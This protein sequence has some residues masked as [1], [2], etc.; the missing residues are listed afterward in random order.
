[1]TR[2]AAPGPRVGGGR[3]RVDAAR[4]I[5]KLREYQLVERAAWVLEGIRAAVAARAT[6]IVLAGDANDIWLSWRGEPWPAEDLTRLFDELVSPEAASERHHLRLLAAAVNSGL[7]LAPAYI[8]VIAIHEH[9]AIRARYTPDVL[10]DPGVDVVDSPLRNMKTETIPVPD[11]AKPGMRV[12]LRRRASLQVL[13]YL[14]GE[15]PELE[16]ARKACADIPVLLTIGANRYHRTEQSRDVVRVPLGDGLEGFLAISDPDTATGTIMEV[17]ERG[18]ILARYPLELPSDVLHPLLSIRLLIDAPRMPTNASRSQV[19]RGSHPIAAAEQRV[20][21]LVPKLIAQLIARLG[22]A[23][24]G[25]TMAGL[26]W[27]TPV[28]ATSS[29]RPLAELPLLRD[30]TGA[31]RALLSRWSGLV[32]RGRTPL[33]S[34]LQ[35]WVDDIVWVPPGD[36]SERLISGAYHQ[37]GELRRRLR[38]ARQQRRD[39]DRFFAHE[40]R[41]PTVI[42]KT[43]PL[44][45]IRLGAEVAGSCVPQDV[46]AGLEGEVCIHLGDGASE[47]VV[48]H[49]GREI[50]RIE[51]TSPIRFDVVIDAPNVTPAARFREL[52]RDGEYARVER[53]MRAGVLRAIEAIAS[54]AIRDPAQ[55]APLI[56]SG[57]VLAKSLGAPLAPPLSTAPAWRTID[58]GC[59]AHAALGEVWAVGI[60]E[61]GI[62]VAPVAGR[63][64][65]R[66]DQRERTR[67]S[68]VA[69]DLVRI[70]YGAAAARPADP[71]DLASR[72]AR[73]NG[74]GL[75]ITEDARS[76]AIGPIGPTETSTIT[77]YHRGLRLDSKP[78][79]HVL[80]PC[81]IA[82]DSDTI[83]P[84]STW[85]R[86][87][88]EG[89]A[90]G[91]Y[92][93][94]EVALVRAA[95][96]ALVGD[97]SLDLIGPSEVDLRGGL[98][99]SMCTALAG[100]GATE[101]L[102][103]ELLA[104]VRAQRMWPVLGDP[105]PKSIDQLC[106][107]HP[108]TIPY[109]RPGAVAVA[110][111]SPLVADDVLATAVATL[112]GLPVRE[113][114]LELETHRHAEVRAKH[115]AKHL[116]RPVQPL[117]Q[118]FTGET[119]TISGPIVRGVVGVAPMAMEIEVFVEGRPFHLIRREELLPLRAAVEIG[120][121]LTMPAF[122]GIPDDVTAEIIAR[123]TEAAHDLLLAIAAA[124]PF[125]L[126][127]FGATR[128]LFAEWCRLATVPL[129]AVTVL[130][131]AP[132]FL[133]VQGGRT[134]IA[135]ACCPL[136]ATTTWTGAW[137]AQDND[138]PHRCDAPVVQITDSTDD[139]PT[140]LRAVHVGEIQDLTDDI[141]RLQATRRMTRGLM[142]KPTIQGVA[143]ELKRSF[144]ELGD[145][146]A[147]LG[148]GEI[149]L[150]GDEGSSA[151]LH[152]GGEL[153]KVVPISVSPSIQI[154]LEAPE[155]IGQ[156]EI[157]IPMRG[158]AFQLK[159]LK[160]DGLLDETKIPQ[161][162]G[163]AIVLTRKILAEVPIDSVGPA[164]RRNLV[165][166]M[167][168]GTLDV[169]ELAG[170]PVF[171]TTVP[172]WIDPV[173]VDKQINL[174]GN[175]WSV[176]HHDA[177]PKPLDDR[178]LVLRIDPA[179]IALA[180]TRGVVIIDASEEL[181]LDDRARKN[182]DKPA[183]TTLA[184]PDSRDVLAQVA[185][186]GNGTTSPRGVVALLRPAAAHLRGLY[187]HREMRPFTPIADEGTW[188]IV[189]TIDD[190]RF[191]PDRTWDRPVDD[192]VWKAAMNAVRTATTQAFST[193]VKVP[194]DALAAE[195]LFGD[196]RSMHPGRFSHIRGALWIAGPPLTSPPIQL[197][198]PSG[199][200]DWVP[201]CDTGLT[202]VLYAQSTD[203]NALARTLRD[204]C[205]E[206]HGRLVRA[207]LRR[208]E[209]GPELVAAHAAHALALSRI[210]AEDASGITFG[211]FRPD[212]LTAHELV[213][214]FAGTGRVRALLADEIGDGLI[215]DGQL[216]SRVVLSH[217]RERVVR[218]APERLSPRVAPPV[219]PQHPLSPL[220][221]AIRE[222]FA[223]IGLDAFNATLVDRA[224]PMF[225]YQGRL[226]VAGDHP[227]L[228]SLAA[229]LAAGSPW[230]S[231][232]LDAVVAHG[233]TVLNVAL[234]EVTDAAEAHAIG[235]LL[236]NA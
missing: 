48:L 203:D 102:G 167:F 148:V 93:E 2:P 36:P 131:T 112:S 45:R 122:D 129:A 166:A 43:L 143:P 189:A 11:G 195:T 186:D 164:I 47:L 34:D 58:G 46:F 155:L 233:A 225:E 101:I 16:I 215:T 147:Q 94:W 83:V 183:A 127:D 174:F 15:P 96:R 41:P 132:I 187:P 182:R 194:G 9:E 145:L 161:A 118:S 85:D 13:S 32:Y 79:L 202:G 64:M 84:S 18:V 37:Q 208:P 54:D 201:P 111:F 214:L 232:M 62:D 205:A 14:F 89:R 25:S 5:A 229:A 204:L 117:A 159:A 149:A 76:G 67:L 190:A 28:F 156:D 42:A 106:A 171:E 136:L 61:P 154:A 224:Q 74:F 114:S 12:H 72:L 146:G 212:P 150:V 175:V 235:A 115:L 209:L 135:D 59:L 1:M 17:A 165:R 27:R 53:A 30:A 31:P 4:A 144:S 226:L 63:H 108:G 228:C 121:S 199:P 220:L 192:V 6:D 153:K 90:A 207:M 60:V 184:L 124:R 75:A 133:T 141:N 71:A 51:H 178:R 188:P 57:L 78:Y 125:A 50:E 29:L 97:R 173:A 120:A 138:P 185:L 137:L 221:Q 158:V 140:I 200:T 163:L 87:L 126:G 49:H 65:L 23:L 100:S 95:A 157:D 109:V 181:A 99:R 68:A 193:L 38:A 20:P 162:Q 139:I 77:L 177:T 3:L 103:A 216:L 116:E 8:D 210:S 56:Q 44:L 35:T 198:L 123:V 234:A 151:L 223:H 206:L 33:D 134:S 230:A 21:E 86:V 73:V 176:P 236:S 10:D 130:R 196:G 169:A 40:A 22:V 222:R 91:N 104:L 191:E 180:L 98:G 7:G 82:V 160:L 152:V 113:A 227:R 179:T 211:C 19:Q 218:V 69:P 39:R 24:L 81:T 52:T 231:A 168:G 110:G 217:V 55:L 80:A 128:R 26:G 70:D 213:E 66:C 197:V 107:A 142:P 92:L 119:V 105:D 88:D 219:V 170:V 172:S